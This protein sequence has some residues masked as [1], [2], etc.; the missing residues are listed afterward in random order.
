MLPDRLPHGNEIT[1]E[2][3]GLPLLVHGTA[4]MVRLRP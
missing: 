3:C 2:V 1:A 4:N